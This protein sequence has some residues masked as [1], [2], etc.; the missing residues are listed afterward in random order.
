[1]IEW[2][3]PKHK[4]YDKA[5]KWVDLLGFKDLIAKGIRISRIF[6]IS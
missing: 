6:K 1:M 4:R 2:S 5:H 3:G